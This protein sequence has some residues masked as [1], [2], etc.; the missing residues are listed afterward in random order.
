MKKILLGLFTLLI[1]S[2]SVFAQP[3]NYYMNPNFGSDGTFTLN[4]PVNGFVSRT[5]QATSASNTF[6]IE[7]D[8]QFNEWYNNSIVTNQSF[9]TSPHKVVNSAHFGHF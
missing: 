7:W 4:T 1:C 2:G 3:S 6:Y 9:P 5:I 8:G